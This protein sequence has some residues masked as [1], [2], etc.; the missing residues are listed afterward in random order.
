[1]M[2]TR[3]LRFSLGLLLACGCYWAQAPEPDGG[4]VRPGSLP[5][6]WRTGGPTCGDAPE[7]EM[8][9]YNPDLYI[10]RENG[11]VNYEKPF[12]YL[13]FGRDKALLI[14]TGAGQ[15]HVAGAVSE[16]IEKWA[17]ANH[18]PALPLVV[19]HSHSHGDHIAGDA[20]FRSRA[21]TTTVPLTVAGT[22]DR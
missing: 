20:Q 8:Q 2:T 9:A 1:M 5:L 22:Q 7:W 16:A 21:N 15:T 6:S 13:F 12:L 10:L 11:C 14:D 19:G 3:S 4:G 18:H 17:A